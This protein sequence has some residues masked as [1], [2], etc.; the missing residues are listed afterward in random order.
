ML[1]VKS[2]PFCLFYLLLFRRAAETESGV[3]KPPVMTWL[4]LLMGLG[5]NAAVD[6]ATTAF[7]VS[8]LTELYDILILHKIKMCYF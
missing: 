1:L 4:Y 8:F 5:K 6:V 7:Q 2:P 3:T